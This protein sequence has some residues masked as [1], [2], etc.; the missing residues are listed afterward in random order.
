MQKC[1]GI[2]LG[3]AIAVCLL[4]CSSAPAP[5]PHG[6][7]PLSNEPEIVA[8]PDEARTAPWIEIA[9]PAPDTSLASGTGGISGVIEDENGKL[10]AGVTI[11]AEDQASDADG[12]AVSGP[13]GV[14][15]IKSLAPGVYR[16]SFYFADV[17]LVAPRAVVA[18]R[19]I[20][21][22]QVGFDTKA[23][24]GERVTIPA[25]DVVP[26]NVPHVTVA[27]VCATVVRL[28]AEDQCAGWEWVTDQ[29]SCESRFEEIGA[30][31][32]LALSGPE[33]ETVEAEIVPAMNAWVR[34]LA[35]A[36]ECADLDVCTNELPE[37]G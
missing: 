35:M 28:Y 15:M 6:I 12:A 22:V 4:A 33:S 11:V 17:T 16:L 3:A 10:L 2:R 26:D 5:A 34:C 32:A 7:G 30:T 18:D 37:A 19:S 24:G 23:L 25:D 29:N 21:S 31:L 9:K 1:T 27:E 8:Q 36:S 14:W 13:G 20:T